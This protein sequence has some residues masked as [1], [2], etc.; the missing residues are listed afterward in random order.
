[1]FACAHT[2][3]HNQTFDVEPLDWRGNLAGNKHKGSFDV[4]VGS[5]IVY[6]RAQ[7]E[8]LVAVCMFVCVSM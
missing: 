1:M 6:D 8:P 5:D 7:G 3:T 2:H 4:I